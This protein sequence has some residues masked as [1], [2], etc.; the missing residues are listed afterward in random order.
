MF[1]TLSFWSYFSWVGDFLEH[2]GRVA[3]IVLAIISIVWFITWLVEV[4]MRIYA[5]F[6]DPEQKGPMGPARLL[7]L[8][9]P[10]MTAVRM[11][12]LAR[13]AMLAKQGVGTAL[14]TARNSPAQHRACGRRAAAR[15]ANRNPLAEDRDLGQESEHEPELCD[16]IGDRFVKQPSAPPAPGH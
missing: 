6:T 4:A 8:V 16:N 5:Q 12:R 9:M 14:T 7:E 13:T 3:A 10:S 11:A 15:R 2:W 1:P